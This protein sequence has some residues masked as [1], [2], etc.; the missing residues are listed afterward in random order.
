M[1]KLLKRLVTKHAWTT[2][3]SAQVSIT[4]KRKDMRVP[5]AF[6]PV[7]KPGSWM[8]GVCLTKVL[9]AMLTVKKGHLDS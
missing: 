9:I 6:T 8:E 5:L 2:L 3:M 7:T 1:Q 4:A